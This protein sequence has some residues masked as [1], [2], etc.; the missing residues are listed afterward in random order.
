MKGQSQEMQGSIVQTM[1]KG[2]SC[3]SSSIMPG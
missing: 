2:K 3:L 1:Q